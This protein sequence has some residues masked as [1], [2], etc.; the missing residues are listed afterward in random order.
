MALSANTALSIRNRR[1]QTVLSGVVL[2]SQVMYHHALAVK[3]AAGLIKVAADETTTTFFGLV[4]IENPDD[5]TAGITGDGTL[6][7]DCISNVDVL[8]PCVTAVTVGNTEAAAYAFDDAQ[9]TAEATLGPE[10]GTFI[11]FVAAN[12][13]WVRLGM[14]ALA[15]AS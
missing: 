13:A 7:V 1:A 14:K 11:E 15:K 6:R 9:A 3:T 4:E 10:I 5:S 8:I 12:S 2:T